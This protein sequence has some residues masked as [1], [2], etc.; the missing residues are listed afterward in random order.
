MMTAKRGP[1]PW[2]LV[3]VG[4]ELGLVVAAMT[5]GGWW[6]D[7]KWGTGPWLMLTGLAVS[8]IGGLY[9]VWRTGQRYMK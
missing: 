3:S 6:L 8:T 7:G 5:L 1:N 2:S 9:K 4:A